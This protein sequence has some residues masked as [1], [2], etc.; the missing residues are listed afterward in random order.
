MELQ[1]GQTIVARDSIRQLILGNS[2][3]LKWVGL[4]FSRLK[5]WYFMLE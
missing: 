1:T 3:I 4:A 2:R 5:T